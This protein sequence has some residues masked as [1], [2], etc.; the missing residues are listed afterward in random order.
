MN[1][2]N[3]LLVD[4]HSVMR[5][6]LRAL[7]GTCR[8]INVCGEAGDGAEGVAKA[9]DLRPDVVIMDL[10]MPEMDGTEATR[11]LRSKWPEAKVLV[12]TTVGASA[13]LSQA[14]EAGASGALLKN[15]ELDELRQAI[16]ATASGTR[17]LSAEILQILSSDPPV[18]KLSPRQ[19]EILQSIS[20]GLTNADIAG[21][22]GISIQMVKEHVTRLYKKL[23]AA[24]RAEA[25]AIALRKHLLKI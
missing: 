16:R 18:D 13:A 7:L 8:E 6:G 3:V 20:E 21:R 14:L 11:L 17:Y 5:N 1:P 15:A 4:D 12:L 2:V 19:L 22:L 24:S 25:V 9:L 10:L 23:G